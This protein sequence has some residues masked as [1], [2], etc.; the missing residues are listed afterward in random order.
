M[1]TKKVA[2]SRKAPSASQKR[3]AK[4]APDSIAFRNATKR[5][6]DIL[7]DGR[8]A[9]A[10]ANKALGKLESTP[11]IG[12]VV[13]DLH[14]L[15]RMMRAYAKGDYR[16]VPWTTVV[17]ATAAVVYFVSP[18]DVIP[19]FVPVAGYIDDVTVVAFVVATIQKDLNAFRGWENG[20]AA[21]APAKAK[22]ASR[23][24]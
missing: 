12:E 3:K 16:E 23:K 6:E 1:A 7:S 22:S 13:N 10:F 4:K 14:T 2:A 8:K 5:A 24:R 21:S 18:V 15:I 9:N 17:G 19:D 20:A 11:G